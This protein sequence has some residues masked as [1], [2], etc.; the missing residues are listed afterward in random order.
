MSE[1]RNRQGWIWGGLLVASLATA[2]V[3]LVDWLSSGDADPAP[4]PLALDQPGMPFDPSGETPEAEPLPEGFVPNLP[5]VPTLPPGARPERATDEGEEG[6]MSDLAAEMRLVQEARAMVATEP[7][8]ALS[9]LEQHR[10][11]FPDGALREEREVY[12]IEALAALGRTDEVERRYLE[13]REDFP[14]S[15]LTERVQRVV[16]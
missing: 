4:A 5:A 1:R 14:E 15:P 16:E 7:A 2:V 6:R 11:R 10:A 12:A 8:V 9:L 3:G 13:F